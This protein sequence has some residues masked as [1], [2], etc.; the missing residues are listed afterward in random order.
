ML[1]RNGLKRGWLLYVWVV[2]VVLVTAGLGMVLNGCATVDEITTNWETMSTGH[3][4][5][6]KAIIFVGTSAI[7]TAGGAVV[8]GAL[9]VEPLPQDIGAY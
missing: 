7:L 5:L 6:E 3:V 1:F 9:T 4:V 2:F 8:Y